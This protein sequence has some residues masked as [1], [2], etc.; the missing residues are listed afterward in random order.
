MP[1]RSTNPRATAHHSTSKTPAD[2]QHIRRQ[3]TRRSRS[4]S[5]PEDLDVGPDHEP[6][7]Q[8]EKPTEAEPP[9]PLQPT[10]E[11][12]SPDQEMEDN[13]YLRPGPV[14]RSQKRRRAAAVNVWDLAKHI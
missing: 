6:E 4:T 3:Y 11:P 14:T 5:E 2:E 7:V 1:N 10:D 8:F 9:P 13:P 12:V